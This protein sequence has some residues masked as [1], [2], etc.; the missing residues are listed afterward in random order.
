ME[1]VGLQ[2]LRVK[3][4]SC[5]AE[6]TLF[7]DEAG[8]A[9]SCGANELAQ[10]GLHASEDSLNTVKRVAQVNGNDSLR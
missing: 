1:I 10:L 7:L 2:G 3:K 5:G 9:Y 6:H 4:I 8:R